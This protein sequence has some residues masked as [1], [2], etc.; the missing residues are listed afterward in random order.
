MDGLSLLR[1]IAALAA[2]LGLIFVAAALLRRSNI[3][4]AA[5]PLPG[6]TIT[7]Q[8]SFHL[9]PRRRL[10]VVRWS[11]E[12][13]LVLL[14]ASGE[15]VVGRRPAPSDSANAPATGSAS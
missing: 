3:S 5:R 9:D 2:T 10:I 14:G 15:T 7:V 8:E 11:G 4:F 1:A 6:R 13:H 12:D